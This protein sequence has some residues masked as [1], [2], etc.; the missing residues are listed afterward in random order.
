V[1]ADTTKPV[2]RGFFQRINPANLFRR[3][4]NTASQAT[5]APLTPAVTASAPP[6]DLSEAPAAQPATANAVPSTKAAAS[7]AQTW[8]R[9]SYRSPAKPAPGDRIRAQPYF[10][11]ALQAQREGRPK[12][13][14]AGYRMAAQLDP[15]FFEARANLG[16]AEYDLGEMEPS[17]A[18]YETALALKPDSART[19]FSF[20]LALRKAGYY[21]D[22]AQ[23]FERVLSASPDDAPAH[24]ALANLYAEQ[25]H[26]P[27]AARQH[28]LRVLAIDPQNPQATDIRFWLNENP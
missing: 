28:Y 24:L 10:D 7:P 4:P 12:D 26:Q 16:L 17:L 19:R 21:L 22:A 13:A 23:E 20:A 1:D 11:Q 9:Y 5:P 8:P 27:Q 14:I 15:A 6:I 2:K 25:F 3:E 18:A